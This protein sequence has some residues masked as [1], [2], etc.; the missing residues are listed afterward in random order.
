[1]TKLA[2]ISLASLA[3]AA[4]TASLI[5]HHHFQV[6]FHEHDAALREQNQQFLA[7]AEEH[8][9]LSNSVAS[10]NI[11]PEADEASELA[12]LRSQAEALKKQTNELAF[13]LSKREVVPPARPAVSPEPDTPEREKKLW[14]ISSEAR[15]LGAA[16]FEYASDH[17]NQ[18][19]ETLDQ[20]ASY[21]AKQ[22][23]SPSGSNQFIILFHG[24]LDQLKGIPLCTV[25]VLRDQRTWM[26]SDGKMVR[27]YGMACGAGQT[28]ASD[29]NFRAWEAL[30]VISPS[31]N[32][33]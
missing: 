22:G 24:S 4:V 3:A 25:A 29:D 20:V 2:I 26:R 31:K 27:I 11:A 19:P 8:Q 21:L 7:L 6:K 16:F 32:N 12:K 14:Q 5:I 9:R 17:Q 28:V 13:Q 15:D 23:R 33:P 30:H 18:L 10:A 1:M